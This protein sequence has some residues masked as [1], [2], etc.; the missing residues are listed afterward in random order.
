MKLKCIP[1]D[2]IVEELYDLEQF[3][4]NDEQRRPYYYFI[5]TKKE[6]TEQRAIEKVA[7]V[8]NTTHKLISYAG[9][10]DK[11]GITKQ[12]ISIYNLHQDWERNVEYFN[13]NVQDI[14]LEF[15][16]EFKGRIHLG[17]N[18]GNKFTV[19]V[20]DITKQEI[21]NAIQKYQEL[22]TLGFANYFDSQRFGYAGNTH[23]VGKYLLQKKPEL[24]LFEFL[25]ALPPTPSEKIATKVDF[26]K[27]N[28]TEIISGT[29]DYSSIKELL[30]R[31][32]EKM[33]NHFKHHKND[34]LGS[35]KMLPKKIITLFFHAYQSYVF[36]TVIKTLTPIERNELKTLELIAAQFNAPEKIKQQML[37]IL[38]KDELTSESFIV[39]FMPE[40]VIENIPRDVSLFVSNIEFVSID[41]DE[42]HQDK[43]KCTLTFTLPS[44]AYATNIVKQLFE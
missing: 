2:F 14:K 30:T 6:Y 9:M 34:C 3:K 35:L 27:R 40:Y 44:S 26:F 18:L 16:G 25:T 29:S 11:S 39:S 32:E 10:K 43:L 33:L 24:A 17:D 38:A 5:L 8:F 1:E 36:N 41:T 4:S 21:D 7:R 28:W 42:L 12:V 13:T 15:I 20:R 19:V 37:D 22:K 23:I 31:D